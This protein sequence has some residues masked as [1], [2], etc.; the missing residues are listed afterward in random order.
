[1]SSQTSTILNSGIKQ[2]E[3]PEIET[4]AELPEKKDNKKK[5]KEDYVDFAIGWISKRTGIPADRIKPEM[6]LR[7][8]LNLDSIRSGELVIVLAKE[9]KAFKSF[10][11]FLIS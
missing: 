4:K 5:T 8:D 11:Q 1:M 7:D 9:L 10:N 6:K 3:V 2:T